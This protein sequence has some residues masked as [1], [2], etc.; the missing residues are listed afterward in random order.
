[1]LQWLKDLFKNKPKEV[2]SKCKGTGEVLVPAMQTHTM[3]QYDVYKCDCK[4]K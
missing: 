4:N 1:M 2:C 3:I